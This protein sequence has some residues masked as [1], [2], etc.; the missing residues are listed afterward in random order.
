MTGKPQPWVHLEVDAAVEGFRA[1]MCGAGTG[2]IRMTRDESAV[3]CGLCLRQMDWR[4]WVRAGLGWP[5]P[6]ET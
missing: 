3:T 5:A 4:N 2:R 6:P 1:V